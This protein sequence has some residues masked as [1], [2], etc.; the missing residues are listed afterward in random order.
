MEQLA[1]FD[2]EKP[3]TSLQATEWIEYRPINQLTDNAAL[4]FNIPAQ[5]SAYLNL[6]RSVLNLKLR[7]TKSD[8]TPVDD[9]QVVGLINVP[10]HSLFSQVEVALQQTPLTHWGIHYPYKAYIDTILKTNKTVQDNLLT[11]QLYYKDVGD[12]DTTDAKTGTNEGLVARYTKTL[13]GHIV[14]IEGPLLLDVFQQPKLLINGVHMGLK[15]YPSTNTFRLIS[16]SASPAEKV[17]IVDARFKVCVQRLN[18]EALLYHQKQI[19]TQPATYPYLRTDIKTIALASGQFSYSVDDLFQGL[20]PST[21]V[22]GLVSS[23]AFNGDYKKNPFNFHHYHCRS[24]GLYVDGQSYPSTPLQPNFEADQ[25]TDCYRT[26]TQFREDINITKDDYKNGYCL[27]LLDIDPYFSFTNKRRGHCRLELK[28]TKAL[29]ESVTIL[30]Y[31]T[32]P[33]ILSIDQSRAVTLQ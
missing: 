20:V 4:E 5:A 30:V 7:L 10:L 13:G 25:Y 15:L 8:N 17:Q 24:V 2:L 22:V 6:K 33:E 31:A 11:S 21:L 14:E 23:A 28:F 26:L 18:N 16:D 32:F 27:Y 3:D 1:L 9:N 29:P 19:Q 12:K